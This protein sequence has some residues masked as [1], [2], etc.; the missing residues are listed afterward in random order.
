MVIILSYWIRL[1]LELKTNIFFFSNSDP[2]KILTVALTDSSNDVF[3]QTVLETYCYEQGIP[4]VKAESKVLKRIL[5][6]TTGEKNAEEK[7]HS[8]CVLLL[9]P[10]NLL[11]CPEESELIKLINQYVLN[12]EE[13][14]IVNSDLPSPNPISAQKQFINQNV[15]HEPMHHEFTWLR[16]WFDH[17][18]L[19]K[20]LDCF[21]LNLN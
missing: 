9:K 17:L 16:A 7:D 13:L 18:N 4:Y 11:N 19:E 12:N 14:V 2:S 3:S 5:K 15:H 10:A 8:S 1:N 20:F 21:N 6:F